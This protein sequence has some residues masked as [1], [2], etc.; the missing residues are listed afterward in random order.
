MTLQQRGPRGQKL[1]R[2]DAFM[3]MD[4]TEKGALNYFLG[5]VACKLFASK[6]LDAP[7]TLH[8]DVYRGA[9]N[10]RLFSVSPP[11]MATLVSV[12]ELDLSIGCTPP[13]RCFY[14]RRTGKGRAK[15]RGNFAVSSLRVAINQMA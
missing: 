13:S 10:P 15:S 4:P 11:E 1:V 12:E 5:L 14:S 2:T 8:L 9:L 6:L 3:Q 7:W